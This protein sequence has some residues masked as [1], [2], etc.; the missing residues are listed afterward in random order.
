MRAPTCPGGEAGPRGPA[1]RPP[2]GTRCQCALATSG[3]T[4]LQ[5]RHSECRCACPLPARPLHAPAPASVTQV[6]LQS[7]TWDPAGCQ[8][9]HLQRAPGTAWCT[10]GAPQGGATHGLGQVTPTVSRESSALRRLP[11]A[12]LPA[13]GRPLSR[14]LLLAF[15]TGSSQARPGWVPSGPSGGIS[16]RS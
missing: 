12:A 8:A 5:P 10:P 14:A 15:S 13:A 1:Q 3:Q 11:R 2:R 16:G 7:P 4:R 6:Q 9:A